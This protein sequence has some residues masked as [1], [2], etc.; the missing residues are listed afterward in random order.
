MKGKWLIDPQSG[1]LSDDATPYAKPFP[2]YGRV[3]DYTCGGQIESPRTYALNLWN[4]GMTAIA[5][6]IGVP[7]HQISISK[8]NPTTTVGGSYYMC[9]NPAVFGPIEAVKAKS[10]DFINTVRQSKPRP[11]QRIR[12]PGE[13]AHENLSQSATTVEVLINH[14]QPFFENIAGQYGLSE[15]SIRAEFAATA[16]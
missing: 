6:P 14:W 11:D 2:G 13:T 5:N 1:E 16:Q 15:A 10:D 4:E 8:K 7:A 9:I 12:I 3:W